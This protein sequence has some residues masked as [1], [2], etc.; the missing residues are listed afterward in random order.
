MLFIFDCIGYV[1]VQLRIVWQ[2][3]ECFKIY[4]GIEILSTVIPRSKPEKAHKIMVFTSSLLL[5]ANSL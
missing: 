3:P 1:T 2:A 5:Q 4:R